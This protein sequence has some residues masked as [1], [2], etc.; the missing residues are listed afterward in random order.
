MSPHLGSPSLEGKIALVTGAARYRGIGR[1]V[2]LDLARRGADVVVHG[3]NRPVEEYPEEEQQIG[4]QG[5]ES[6]V[7]EITA[8]G[9]RAVGIESDFLDRSAPASL[10]EFGQDQLGPITVLVNNAAMAGST[11]RGDILDLD[12]DEWFRMVEMNLNSTYLC[13][14]AALPSMVQAGE[15]A[16]VNIS[17]LAG[18]RAH[19]L[20]GAYTPT[21][22]A[23]VGF[24]QQLALE[25][26]PSIRV[27]CVCP[28]S[29]ATDMMAGTYGR[30][31]ERVGADASRVRSHVIGRIPLEREGEP[32]EIARVISFLCSPEASFVTGQTIAVDGGQ[33]LVIA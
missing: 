33:N 5:V 19:P 4:W 17:S 13:C 11:G 3:R 21:K 31:A 24:S 27:N 1:A 29:T 23:I 25:F 6:V 22:F 12:D 26:A 7:E 32:E 18:L 2:A 10:V 9:Q 16:I 8:L 14:K 20:F 30:I 28:G 15:G